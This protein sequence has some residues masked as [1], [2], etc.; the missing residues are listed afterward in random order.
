MTTQPPIGPEKAAEFARSMRGHYI[1]SQA[2]HTAILTLSKVDEP[3]QEVSNIADMKYLLYN[4]NPELNHIHKEMES[5]KNLG[6]S[7]GEI[8]TTI[9]VKGDDGDDNEDET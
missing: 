5:A 3:Y 8:I 9:L 6:G 4:L 7:M 2:L 1:I